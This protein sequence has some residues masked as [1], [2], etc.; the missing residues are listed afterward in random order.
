MEAEQIQKM[1]YSIDTEKLFFAKTQAR[2]SPVFQAENPA[3]WR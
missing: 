2:E 1:S 3:W